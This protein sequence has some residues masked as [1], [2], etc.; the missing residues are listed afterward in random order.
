MRHALRGKDR[1][2]AVFL[3]PYLKVSE[4]KQLFNELVFLASFTHGETKAIRD[5]ILSLPREWV[6]G[7]IEAAVEPLLRKGTYEEYRRL[8]ELLIEIDRDIALNFAH[9][10]AEHPDHDIREGGEDF[11]ERLRDMDGGKD[12]GQSEHF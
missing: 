5:A 2:T 10:A 7:N 4:L 1:A 12:N 8:L 6:I 9:Q 11:L 3:L